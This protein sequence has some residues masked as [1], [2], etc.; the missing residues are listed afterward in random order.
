MHVPYEKILNTLA[1]LVPSKYRKSLREFGGQ[2]K[3]KSNVAYT[4]KNKKVVLKQLRKKIKKQKLIVAFYVYDDPK[5]KCQT[6]YDLMEKSDYFIPYI[7]ACKNVSPK[8]YSGYQPPEL[9]N[10]TYEFFKNKNMR[11]LY[12]YD[13][14]NEKFIPTENM[15]PRPDIIFYQHPWYVHTAQGP[16]VNSKFALTFYVP[17]FLAT[18]LSPIEYYLRFHKYVQTHYVLNNQIKDYFSQNME[19][20]GSNL[21]AVGHPQLDY[22]YL[23]KDKKYENK[24]YVIYAPHWSIDNEAILNWGTFLWSGKFMLDFAMKNPQINWVFKPHPGLIQLLRLR[25]MSEQ[26]IQQYWKKWAEVG[27]VCESGD[28]LD[29]FMES[30]AMITDCGSFETEYFMT[31]KPLIYL[32]SSNG[33]PFNP[34]VQKITEN[35]YKAENVQELERAL[36]TVI[37]EKNDY[38]K[39]QRINSL[40]ELGYKDNFAAQNIIDD[41]KKIL[42]VD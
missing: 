23:N 3:I 14:E 40:E 5:W 35:Y 36:N 24:N 33:T 2:L 13:V 10:K 34:A 37:L 41:L 11:V 27:I 20:K 39:E 8:N 18:S 38:M 9:V 30:S 12:G 4:L 19:N 31:K 22:F 25:H 42:S 7:H 16:V 21:K 17:Y 6:L 26:D 28:Y 1:L 32:K 29:L 15:N